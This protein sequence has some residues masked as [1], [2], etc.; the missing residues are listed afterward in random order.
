LNI[1]CPISVKQ[2][3][4]LNCSSFYKVRFHLSHPNFNI[5]DEASCRPVTEGS[6][7]GRAYKRQASAKDQ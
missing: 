5:A 4:V 6:D 3:K 7:Y 1:Y 2:K